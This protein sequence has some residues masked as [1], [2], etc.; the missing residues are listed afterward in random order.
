[1]AV[2]RQRYNSA[3]P[4]C[5]HRHREKKFQLQQADTRIRKEMQKAESYKMLMVQVEYV[6]KQITEYNAYGFEIIGIIGA[7]RSPNCGVETTSDFN[8]EINGKGIFMS[9]L[10][11]RINAENLNIPMLGIKGTDN[12]LEQVKSII[13]VCQN[14]E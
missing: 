6:M 12:V 8:K 9:E 7:N 3:S 11:N 2:L 14:F 13:P 10:S 5:I 4:H 1:M